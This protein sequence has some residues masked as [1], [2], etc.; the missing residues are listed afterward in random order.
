[1]TGAGR[2]QKMNMGF[3]RR[4]V[5]YVLAVFAGCTAV[6][7]GYGLLMGSIGE[8]GGDSEYYVLRAREI[9][10]GGIRFYLDNL[11]T[12]Y[13]WGYPTFLALVMTFLGENWEAVA[14]AQVILSSV[15]AIFLFRIL[16]GVSESLGGAAVLAVAYKL[17]LDVSMWDGR[18]LSDSLGMTLECMTLH[19]F[20]RI[21]LEN[22]KR[23]YVLFAVYAFLFWTMRTNAVSLLIVLASVLFMRLPAGK[24]WIVGGVCLFIFVTAFTGMVVLGSGDPHGLGARADYYLDY[25]RNGI[26]VSG[27]PEYDYK[28]LQDRVGT[29]WFL[30]D[31]FC[32]ILLK[33]KYYWSIYFDAYSTVHKVLCCVTILPVFLFSGFSFVW[34]VKERKKELFPFLGGVISYSF[35]QICTEVD[36]DMRYRAPVFALLVVCSGYGMRKVIDAR[37]RKSE[38]GFT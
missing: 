14:V 36:F 8:F 12:P 1:M 24:K 19:F 34:I 25:Y 26:V 20:Y 35:F 2:K 17:V 15:S 30:A 37:R 7:I 38:D 4:K 33:T 11:S 27:R 23:D 5:A 31:I 28:V 6:S 9:Q 29:I 21:T 3:N 22:K 18:I 13:Y 16:E 10:A 32:M